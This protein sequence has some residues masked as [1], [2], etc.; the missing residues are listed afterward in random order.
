MQRPCTYH[1]I[2][3][4]EIAGMPSFRLLHVYKKF[5]FKVL[6]ILILLMI[7]LHWNT[8]SQPLLEVA[9]MY[10]QINMHSTAVCISFQN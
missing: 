9:L 7:I 3:K 4:L 2:C 1:Q 5:V 8:Q 10:E 6:L